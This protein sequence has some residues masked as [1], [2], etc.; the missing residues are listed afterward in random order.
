MKYL[1][2][3]VI[4]YAIEG[5]PKYGRACGKIL[6]DIQAGR[7]KAACSIL[8]LVELIS[9][10]RKVNRELERRRLPPLDIR[11]NIDAVLSLPITW[12]EL[13]V[14]LLKRAAEYQYN[15]HGADYVHLA[16]LELH[17]IREIIS[18]D[19]DFDKAGFVKRIDPLEY[20]A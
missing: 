10:L 7:L 4:G 15:I 14:F 3:N 2:T 20:A 11:A 16:S 6:A 18:A 19:S 1:D 5:H 17:D 8:V 13:G 9:V 12:L